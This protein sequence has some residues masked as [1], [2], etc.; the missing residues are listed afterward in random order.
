[1]FGLWPTELKKKLWN[2]KKNSELANWQIPHWK[3]I[4]L[5]SLK[6]SCNQLASLCSELIFFSYH[7][8][9]ITWKGTLWQLWKVSTLVSLCSPCRQTTVKTFCYWQ[10]FCDN[11]PNLTVT[12]KLSNNSISLSLLHSHF[13]LSRSS[14]KVPFCVTS[15]IFIM[16]REWAN[17]SPHN[18]ISAAYDKLT[19]SQTTNFR[20]FKTE[21]V[22]RRHIQIWWKWEKVLQMGRKQCVKR[23]NCLLRAISPFPIVFSKCLYSRHV[24]TRVCLGKG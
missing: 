15:H 21:R 9:P 13:F 6:M 11:L 3:E 2:T 14:N 5:Y 16:I 23:R 12:L 10:I 24:K 19:L 1:M 8:W 17:P 22:C 4:I 20:F 7:L 18:S